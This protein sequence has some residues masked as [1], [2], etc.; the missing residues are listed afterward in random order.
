MCKTNL[1]ALFPAL[2]TFL[3]LIFCKLVC[4]ASF[5]VS[6]LKAP[7]LPEPSDTDLNL[8]T[9]SCCAIDF[10]YSPVI[11][12]KHTHSLS[13]PMR[14]RQ[15]GVKDDNLCWAEQMPSAELAT[16][17]TLAC[18]CRHWTM[19]KKRAMPVQRSCWLAASFI[20]SL[21]KSLSIRGNFQAALGQLADI[22]FKLCWPFESVSDGQG[23]GECSH[24]F[25]GWVVRVLP[26]SNSI[27]THRLMHSSH[28]VK[29]WSKK[30]D[31]SSG[32][33]VKNAAAYFLPFTSELS[34]W[35]WVLL[36]AL[37]APALHNW[38]H[39]ELAHRLLAFTVQ[40][41]CAWRSHLKQTVQVCLSLSVQVVSLPSTQHLLP[42]TPDPWQHQ[43][44]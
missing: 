24:L 12:A 19:P 25:W 40:F 8:H 13:Q 35:T 5:P 43:D 27:Y 33:E 30:S 15:V 32:G 18:E 38:K 2:P 16:T 7:C 42:Y 17:Q 14:T 41:V 23:T 4:P 10:P 44:N 9:K 26:V 34:S 22:W 20:Y 28:N 1:P 39:I 31:S 29:L 36:P 6:D 21:T 37:F 11:S 3:P